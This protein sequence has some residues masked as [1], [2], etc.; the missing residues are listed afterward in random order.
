MNDD[1]KGLD[2]EQLVVLARDG[3]SEAFAEVYGRH[4]PGVARALA[5]FAGTDRDLLDDLVQDVFLRVTRGLASYEP[6]RPFA[7]WLYT[8]ALNVGRNHARRSA[9]VIPV[10]PADL[11]DVAAAGGGTD[12]TISLTRLVARLPVAMREVVSLRVGS[13]MSYGEI[14]D[15]LGIPEGTARSRMHN[16]LQLLRGHFDAPDQRRSNEHD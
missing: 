15:L 8:V 4:A 5:S 7:H 11:D 12:E 9:A 3:S 10:D 1:L 6:S 16:A 2:D 14:A 13:E